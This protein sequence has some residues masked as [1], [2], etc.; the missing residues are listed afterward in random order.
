MRPNT[1]SIA[2][3]LTFLVICFSSLVAVLMTAVQL[4]LD[5]RRDLL[6]L[7]AFFTS[8]GET[9][10]R[11]LEESVWVLDDLQINLQLEGLTKREGIVHAAVEMNGEVVWQ[12]GAPAEGKSILRLYPLV[13]RNGHRQEEIGRLRVEAS[14]RPIHE[15][16]FDRIVILL[17]SN[18]LKTFVVS[19]FILFLFQKHLTSHL[20]RM[21]EHIRAI[22]V[23]VEH[24]APLI[25]ERAAPRRPDELEQVVSGFNS[26]CQSGSDF[27][28][29]L[30]RQEERLRLFLDATDEAVF[31]VDSLGVC[32]FAN[33]TCLECFQVV[34]EKA[35]VG[36]DLLGRLETSSPPDKR[37]ATPRALVESSLHEDR[38]LTA[39]N[40]ILH[41]SDGTS[42]PISLR[43]YPV[44]D[45]GGCVG[46]IV[47]FADNSRLQHLEREKLLFARVIG[48]APALILIT[49]AAGVIEYGNAALTHLL[50]QSAKQMSGR[51]VV[52][53]LRQIGI[54]PGAQL[55][56][57]RAAISRGRNATG[58]FSF[59]KPDGQRISLEVE[60]LPIRDSQGNLEHLMMLGRDVTREQ[61]LLEQLQNAQ[62][63]KAI[64]QLAASLA[65]E[66]GNPLLGIRFALRDITQRPGLA[67]DAR[68]VLH[69]AEKECDRMRSLLRELQHL[70]RPST[71]RLT[72][73]DLHPLLDSLLALHRNYM[74]ERNILVRRAYH[75]QAIK[76]AVVEDQIR[77]VFVNLLLNTGEA[78]AKQGG[79]L[80]MGTTIEDETVLISVEDTGPGIAPEHLERLFEPFFT[81]KT[82]S[83]GTGLGLAVSY[84]I[85]Q[86][87][88]GVI[89]ARSSPGKTRFT[90]RLPLQPGAMAVEEAGDGPTS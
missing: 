82:A 77:Q 9:S 13:H 52:D 24:P 75:T 41:R 47:F 2:Y 60:I 33:R 14:L 23:R 80:T 54:D 30:R 21:A 70:N 48:Q 28:N 65:H 73:C 25:L 29:Q 46:A 51:P 74:D 34:D 15:R 71:G 58:Q 22:D 39:D 18:T 85:I 5:Y 31:G 61:E 76:L 53:C 69:L 11:P 32:T 66:F 88:G 56:R 81:T 49:D 57:I 4:A 78:M 90:V 36:S 72:L 89:E 35:I 79:V 3:R 44:R 37:A 26:L 17:I 42:L 12:M 40:L 50:G 1:A 27:F 43:S 6:D 86:G 62:K 55:D 19:G 83:G 59:V 87:H 84:G 68:E 63:M 10:L 64:G 16:I 8:I 38:V 7:Y 67:D 45:Q 20:V